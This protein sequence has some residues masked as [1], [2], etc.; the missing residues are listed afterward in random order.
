MRFVGHRKAFLPALDRSWLKTFDII[1][2]HATDQIVDLLALM[3]LAGLPPIML[4]THGLFFHTDDLKRIK[5]AY[6]RTISRFTLSRIREIFAVSAN[7]QAILRS[8]VY[9]LGFCSGRAEPKVIELMSWWADR[10]E[11]DCRVDLANGLFTDQ[12]WMDMSPGFVDSVALHRAPDMNLAYWNLEGRTL[13]DMVDSD[14]HAESAARD[15]DANA[16]RSEPR[17]LRP[18]R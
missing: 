18:R 17:A 3:S 12:K 10:C 16:A 2:V 15:P 5:Q 7:D 4:T 1:H 11:F 13:A 6:L 9:N 14:V 8:G